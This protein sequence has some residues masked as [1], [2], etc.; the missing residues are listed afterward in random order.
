MKAYPLVG[1]HTISYSMEYVSQAANRCVVLPY[2][3][4]SITMT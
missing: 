4:R 2:M 3:L 1:L